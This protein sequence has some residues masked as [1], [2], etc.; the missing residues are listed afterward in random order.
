MAQGVGN[1]ERDPSSWRV[2]PALELT[3]QKI[4][5]TRVVTLRVREIGELQKVG[6]TTMASATSPVASAQLQPKNKLVRY[7]SA[8]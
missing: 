8:H 5:G 2:R 7:A 6:H 3:E 4:R 1:G